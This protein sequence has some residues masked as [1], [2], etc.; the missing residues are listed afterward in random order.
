MLNLTPALR[1]FFMARVRA[2]LLWADPDGMERTQK[3]VLRQLLRRAATTETG[4]RYGFTALDTYGK[5]ASAVPVTEYEDIRGDVMRMIAGESDILWPGRCRRFAQSSGT[6][7][8][9]SKYIPVTDDSLRVNHYAGGR[10]VVAHYLGRT[11]RSRIFAGKSFILGG[12][13]ANELRDIPKGVR[14]GD[15]S[16]NL[17]ENINPAVNLLRVPSRKVALMAD[18]T[19]KLPALVEASVRENITN[20]SGVPS[21]FLGVLKGILERTGAS[22]IHDIWPKLEVFFHGGIAFSPYRGQ[23]DTILDSRRMHYVDTYNASEGFFA[24]QDSDETTAMRLLADIGI[25]YEFDPLD[26]NGEP[27]GR[28]VPAWEV[29]EGRTYAL[30]IS[31]CNGLWRYSIGDTVLV[32]STRPLRIRIAGRTHCYINAFGEELMVWNADEA[33]SRTCQQCGAS[34]ADYTAAPVY[35]DSKDRGCH[36]WLIE[37]NNAPLCGNEAFADILDRELQRVNSDYQAKR[38]GD[39]FLRRLILTEIPRGTFNRW[40]AATGK[41]GGQRKVPRLENDRKIIDSILSY[42][43]N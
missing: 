43:K 37:W 36:Q 26:E 9:K 16:A 2:S 25:F 12:S 6:S 35:T 34:V 20:I 18:W 41:L 21:W 8:G 14:V 22:S 4:R 1:P 17:I 15:L 3:A 33:L 39:I 7:G 13:F 40:L 11:P 38:S 23:Y 27:C 19:H 10:D 24:V 28:P 42:A 32:E 31:S 5:Y 29:E 30:I